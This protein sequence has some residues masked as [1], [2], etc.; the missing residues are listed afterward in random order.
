[1]KP[2]AGLAALLALALSVGGGCGKSDDSKSKSAGS[3]GAAGAPAKPTGE[4]NFDT[5]T[6]AWQNAAL[7]KVSDAVDGV[8]FSVELPERLSRE[9]KKNDGTFPG[10]VTWNGPNAFLDPSFTA[11]EVTFP[12]ADLAAAENSMKRGGEPR[13]VV[14]SEELEGG[15]YLVS[16][17]ETSRKYIS[18]QVWK[19][20][21]ATKKV[22]RF[23]IGQ[24]SSN[25]IAELDA[26]RQWM[27]KVVTTF[28]V[29]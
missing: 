8:A 28:S 7:T 5:P 11:Q 14:R 26:L 2:Y 3:G 20:S 23:S 22:F 25:P 24:R 9:E 13:D 10:Y 21:A 4:V 27:E 6:V 12:P 1:M 16:V 18:V 19:T 17:I 15:G 29:E